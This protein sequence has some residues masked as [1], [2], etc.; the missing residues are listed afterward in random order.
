[1]DNAGLIR[2]SCAMYDNCFAWNI[3]NIAMVMVVSMVMKGTDA[4][5]SIN[6]RVK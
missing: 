6:T 1:M 2:G 5:L 4:N 3:T